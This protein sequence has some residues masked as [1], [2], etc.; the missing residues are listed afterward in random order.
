MSV[1]TVILVISLLVCSQLTLA[2]DR[3]YLLAGRMVDVVDGRLLSDRTIVI[4]GDR[5]E[6]VAASSSVDIPAGADVVD[7]GDMTVLPGLLDMHVHLAGDT[8]AKGYRRLEASIPR[9]ALHGAANAREASG[10][11]L[12]G[13]SAFGR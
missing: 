10:P 8:K 7:L 3:T 2:Q 1:R 13:T 9:I 4:A 5:I 11:R 12:E 6:R